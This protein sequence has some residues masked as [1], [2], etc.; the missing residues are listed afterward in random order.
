MCCGRITLQKE[1]I[2]IINEVYSI[3][4][5]L[6]LLLLV[7]SSGIGYGCKAQSTSKS[8]KN[9]YTLVAYNVENLFDADSQA[10]FD[11]YKWLDKDGN[12]QYTNLDVLT[13]I[14]HIV[15]TLKQYNKGK[16]PDVI[17]MAEVESDFTPTAGESK[18]MDD[19][20]FLG[21]YKMY[22]LEQMLGEGFNKEIADIPAELLLLK[23][24]TDAG[25]WNYQ[26]EVGYSPKNEKGLLEN[27]QKNVIYSRFPIKKELT[28]VHPLERARPILEV[29]IDVDGSNLV[30]FANHWK[31]GA[32]SEEMEEVR[33]Q[34][35]DVLKARIDDLRKQN[36]DVD[37][38][39][40]GDFNSDYNQKT[41][42]K[43]KKTAINTVLKSYGE[44]ADFASFPNDRVYNLWYE[45]PLD[46]RGSDTY[47]GQWGTLMQ[48][49]ISHGMYDDKGVHYVDNSFSVGHFDFNTYSTSGE[50]KRWSSVGNG[51]GYSDHLPVSMKFTV[52][53]TLAELVKPS[54]DDDYM[55]QPLSL[56]YKIPES[57][58][59][60]KD[61][62][63]KDPAS[64]PEFFD[65]YVYL[66]GILT[67][68][69]DV[70]VNGVVYDVYTPSFKM[71]DVLPDYAGTDKTFR[72][73]GR[74]SQYKGNWQFVIEDTSFIIK[75]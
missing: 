38:V 18:W 74:F 17:V 39:L 13:K 36:P 44:E 59:S 29:W 43:F 12:P 50:P 1:R 42:Y 4:K 26:V 65:Q 66:T 45:L 57:F 69:Y 30:V 14:E 16:G 48:I 60:E 52:S 68:E 21:Q 64:H 70:E 33:L 54:V 56:T 10:V 75:E 7:I 61:F 11:D 49:M 32:S 62:L 22:S 41:R 19:G 40:A 53:N 63:M 15:Q 34:N 8:Q 28:L 25:L 3:M 47:R 31:A 24:M 73:Y 46:K 58:I 72:F 2:T 71:S 6:I 9:I 20:D 67:S 5:K 27:V 55:W 37:F 35:A 51:S 23:G